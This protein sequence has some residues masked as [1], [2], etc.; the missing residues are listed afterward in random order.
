MLAGFLKIVPLFI[1]VI[2][3]AMAISVLPGLENGDA[4]FPKAVME[5]LPI[6]MIGIVLAGLISA[7]MSSVDS[8]LNSASTLFVV[9]FVK[10]NNPNISEKEVAG[11]GRATTIVLMLVAAAW[12]PMIEMVGVFYK[13]GNG[14]GAFWT[15]VIGTLL[16]IVLFVA[17]QMEFSNLHYTY[18]VGIMVGVS[19]L[20]F[21][22]ASNMTEA[23]SEEKIANYTFRRELLS[24]GMEGVAWYS[25]YRFHAA[26]L[27]LLM[28]YILYL[29]W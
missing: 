1:M 10:P 15:L 17:G 28:G 18:N 2:P 5:V 8:T 4:V 24:D 25:D 21:I 3:G 29:F 19:T 9:D 20:I 11:F 12:A 26:L 14:D 27:M 22:V 13:R 23:P 6:G 16:G 7:I